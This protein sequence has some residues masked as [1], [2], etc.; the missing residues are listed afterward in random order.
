[1]IRITPLPTEAPVSALTHGQLL[2]QVVS[3]YEL[4]LSAE[5]ISWQKVDGWL[6]TWLEEPVTEP[7]NWIGQPLVDEDTAVVAR[8]MWR[9]ALGVGKLL[10]V[11]GIPVLSKPSLFSIVPCSAHSNQW[12]VQVAMTVQSDIPTNL[13]EKMFSVLGAWLGRVADAEDTEEVLALF[14]QDLERDLL[15]YLLNHSQLTSSAITLLESAHKMHR[16]WLYHGY[17]I[18]QLGWGDKSL[19]FLNSLIE[20][21][22]VLGIDTVAHKQA[23]ALWLREA[24]L[25]TA[26]HLLVNTPE[27]AVKAAQRLGY[28]LVIKPVNAERGEGVS[29]DLECEQDV[30]EAF[31]LAQ[32][33]SKQV[34]VEE[35][36]AG[37]CHRL[38][39]VRGQLI[40][41]V[42][43]LPVAVLGDGEHTIDELINQT[44]QVW[45]KRS[46][47]RRPP[48]LPHGE[49]AES[50]LNRRGLRLCDVPPAGEWVELHRIESTAL[51]GRDENMISKI[52]RDN[53][54]LAIKAAELFDLDVAGVDLIT[55][56]ISLPWYES[57]A[58]INEVNASP[59]L[60]AGQ[61]SLDTMP[62]VVNALLCDQGR[63]SIDVYVGGL[64]AFKA[65]EQRQ[66]A[67]IQS[68][69]AAFLTSHHHTKDNTLATWVMAEFGLYARCQA[70]LMH[71]AVEA[72]VLVIQNE[73]WLQTGLPIDQIDRVEHIDSDGL[74]AAHQLCDFLQQFVVPANEGD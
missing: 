47:W 35:Q 44:M 24:N 73:D 18:A 38:L 15:P 59:S 70:L 53:V 27:L 1:M 30:I 41:V 49:Q 2:P 4:K 11:C 14:Y 69:V 29:V 7:Q 31:R 17:G 72:I 63:I 74:E 32:R 25:P 28:P 33:F 71:R 19:K 6:E 21:D 46:P 16:P 22:S 36:V 23:T 60:G 45:K 3:L 10:R 48:P 66:K 58:I 13:F 57:G 43:R 42:K 50:Y 67:L 12:Q 9:I 20:T 39:I 62:D 52:H 34:L 5:P 40:Y 65:A 61:C 26:Q 54:S 51:G 37:V 55:A 8:L 56:D 68:G 64:A